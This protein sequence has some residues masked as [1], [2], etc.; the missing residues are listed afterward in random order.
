MR[1]VRVM[2]FVS[3]KARDTVLRNAFQHQCVSGKAVVITRRFVRNRARSLRR[4]VHISL[5][6]C[7]IACCRNDNVIAVF[8]SARLRTAGLRATTI[9]VLFKST[10][11]AVQ[12]RA[13]VPVPVIPWG[14]E[15]LLLCVNPQRDESN[16]NSH[17]A[18]NAE[19]R[20]DIERRSLGE[21]PSVGDVLQIVDDFPQTCCRHDIFQYGHSSRHEEGNDKHWDL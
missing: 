16:K 3:L 19:Q 15:G 11:N 6:V 2:P 5:H 4:D 10:A 20:R 21:H 9:D 13:K 18:C 1:P 14:G 17:E 8:F 7:A 12:A